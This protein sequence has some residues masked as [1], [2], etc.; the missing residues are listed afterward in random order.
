VSKREKLYVVESTYKVTGTAWIRATSARE[1]IEKGLN[2]DEHDV[3][4]FFSDPHSETKMRAVVE[5]DPRMD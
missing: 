1:A 4:F 3:T 5:R 2:P